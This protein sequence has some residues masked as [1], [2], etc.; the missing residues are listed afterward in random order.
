MKTD[1]KNAVLLHSYSKEMSG[2]FS[3]QDLRALFGQDNGVQLHRH[4]SSLVDSG[5]LSRFCRG[6]YT[7]PGYVPEVLAMRVITESYL[8]LGT[9]LAKELMIGSVPAHTLYA[10]RVGPSRTFVGPGLTIEY[11]GIAKPLF[12]GFRH[13]NGVRY[14]TPEKALLDTLYFHSHGRRFSFDIYEDIEVSRVDRRIV[15]DYLTRYRNPRFTSYVKGYLD[16]RS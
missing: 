15:A 3:T 10:I 14:A 8:S 9:V 7:T 16:D 5:L 12:F 1:L 6:F 4:L 2:V 13:E 11:L